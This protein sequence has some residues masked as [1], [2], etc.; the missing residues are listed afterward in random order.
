MKLETSKEDLYKW[1]RLL[2][3][4]PAS[5]DSHT[6]VSFLDQLLIFGGSINSKSNNDIYKFN[7]TTKIWTKLEPIADPGCLPAPREG[8]KAVLI[9]GDKMLIHG[10]IDE[11]QN[12]F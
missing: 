9:E 5:R 3:E 12:C 7:I 11:N 1:K 2:G 4:A 8:H 6:C 10:G